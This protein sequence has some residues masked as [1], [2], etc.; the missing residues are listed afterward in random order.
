[1]QSRSLYHK[2]FSDLIPPPQ[3]LEMPSV[4]LD[5]SDTVIRFAE[6][7]RKNQH[8]ELGIFGAEQLPP[9]VIS[10]G[11]VKDKDVLVKALTTIRKKHN[12]RFVNAS[13]PEEK[14]YLFTTTI[15]Y[16]D[17]AD[18]RDALRYKIEEN[19][20]VHLSDA[21]FDYLF[22]RQPQPGDTEIELGVAVIHTKVVTSYLEAL[23]AAGLVP[24]ELRIE[25]QA[26]AQA[27]VP[28]GDMDTYILV[29]VRETKTVVA[30][31]S[32]GS[33]RYSSTISVGGKSLASSLQKSFATDEA[34]TKK[35]REGKESKESNEMFMSLVNAGSV[36]RDEIKKLF[37]YL[38][39][40]GNDK[41]EVK[42]IVVCGSDALLGLDEYLTR[43]LDL[44]VKVANVWTNILSLDKYVPPITNRESLDYA[45]ALGLALPL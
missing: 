29:T 21:V 1:M 25:S 15:P 12:L 18:I 4:G 23:H 26:I 3:F 39:N 36:V 11:Y 14:S 43:S 17:V 19:V 34:G 44:P 2:I 41:Q 9:D 32:Q 35:I 7:K 27:V 13:L 45:S 22:I 8:F 42:H 37:T 20:P 28:R 6:L 5:I 33:I 10:E 38:E 40:H 24:L 30:I 31:V 16:M